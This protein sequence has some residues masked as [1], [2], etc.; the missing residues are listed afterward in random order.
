L[1]KYSTYLLY[2]VLSKNQDIIEDKLLGV[3]NNPEIKIEVWKSAIIQLTSIL[4]VVFS[5]PLYF[6]SIKQ[7]DPATNEYIFDVRVYNNNISRRYDERSSRISDDYQVKESE[8]QLDE[9]EFIHLFPL[10]LIKND[11]LFIYKRTAPPR[12][13]YFSVALNQFHI[14]NTT[15]KFSSLI[16]RTGSE[17]ELFWT[18]IIPYVN[19]KNGIKANIPEEGPGEFIGRRKLINQIKEEILGLVNENGILYG[20]G[21]IGK[22]SL[23]LELTKELYYEEKFV[24]NV[25]FKNII[26]VSAKKDYYDYIHDTIEVREPQASVF[27]NVLYAILRFFDIENLKEYST[28]DLEELVLVLLRENKILLILDNFET[29]ENNEQIIQFFNK[30]VKK[31]LKRNPENFKIILTS[32]ELVP[33]GFNQIPVSGLEL[34]DS[35][36]LMTS[37][38]KKYKHSIELKNEQKELLHRTVKGI[39]ILLKHCF[40]RI[41]E[42]NEPFDSVINNLPSLS[43]QIVQFSFK[44]ILDRVQ[45]EKNQIGLQILVLL[46]IVKRPLMVRQ[47]ADILELTELDLQNSLPNLSNFECVHRKM[48]D[49]QEK[50]YVNDEISLLVQ[51]L[52]RENR[53]L[54]HGI[55]KK[56]FNNFSIDKQMDY[57][58]DEENQIS[59]FNDYI[60]DGQF[61]AGSDFLK[62]Q[63]RK[64]SDSII[65]NYHYAMYLKNS[66]INIPEAIKILEKLTEKSGNH[67]SVVKL[68]FSCYATK[69][70]PDFEKAHGLIVQIISDLGD[71]LDADIQMDIARFYIS[72]A[73]NLR[74]EKGRDEYEDNQRIHKYKVYAQKVV[75]LL[76]PIESKI[77]DPTWNSMTSNFDKIELYYLL[78]Q[79]YFHQW[80]HNLAIKMINKAISLA[81]PKNPSLKTFQILREKI[82]KGQNFYSN[83][84][85][86]G[87]TGDD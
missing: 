72:W 26:W 65:L 82:L 58:S 80:E 43:S 29:L 45:R 78:S 36:R 76:A 46:E 56:Y 14:E 19:P 54:Y 32:R 53:S 41:Y 17:Q 30:R 13:E 49:N 16:L 48:I 22:T 62:E 18:D 55:R 3:E 74:K 60:K 38:Y 20:P 9:N 51:N 11:A 50:Y 42:Y 66:G 21:G 67:P 87:R 4:D 8:M 77:G 83:N 81:G 2:A 34:G 70:N 59:I 85:W 69:D 27:R 44:E 5:N 7:F 63:L 73:S 28:N 37:L 31:E 40:A 52:I 10:L 86:A 6:R 47:M 68:L 24:E 61:S 79:A 12:H 25:S 23:M 33:T 57:S 35:K 39:P 71:N 15:A 64:N 84:R 75:D 1:S